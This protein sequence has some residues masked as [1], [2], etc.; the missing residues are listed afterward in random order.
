MKSSSLELVLGIMPKLLSTTS[1]QRDCPTY[2]H[3]YQLIQIQL[4]SCADR[5]NNLIANHLHKQH[6]SNYFIIRVI[7]QLSCVR[8]AL[9]VLSNRVSVVNCQRIS[10]SR[11]T[12]E[13]ETSSVKLNQVLKR[14]RQ[15]VLCVCMRACEG[16]AFCDERGIK[17]QF[18]VFYLIDFRNDTQQK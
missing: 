8:R 11:V 13:Y 7:N 9:G 6:L 3:L 18:G 15:N 4:L 10:I 12:Y 1:P 14:Q 17:L 2:D 5:E 16:T